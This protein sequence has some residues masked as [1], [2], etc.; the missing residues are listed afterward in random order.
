MREKTK[1]YILMVFC[2][3]YLIA[4][5]WNVGGYIAYEIPLHI[6]WDKIFIVGS[7]MGSMLLFIVHTLLKL[8]FGKD[9]M[10]KC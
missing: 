1:I 5:L 6:D 7:I 4:F 8:E 2:L 9:Y 10:K 3:G